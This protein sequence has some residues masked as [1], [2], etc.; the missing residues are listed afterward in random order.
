MSSRS[1]RAGRFSMSKKARK[2][3]RHAV[4][5]A[6]ELGLYSV[7]VRGAVWTLRH[8]KPQ[9]EN[10]SSAPPQRGAGGDCCCC[11]AGSS[12]SRSPR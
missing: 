6:E 12:G 11:T 10:R 3:V 7:A 1:S 9:K 4:E 8:T 5:L 2:E